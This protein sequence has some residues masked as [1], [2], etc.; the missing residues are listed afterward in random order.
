[1]IRSAIF[2]LLLTISC[3]IHAELCK[4]IDSGGS[5]HYTS[6]PPDSSWRLVECYG[7]DDKAA[8]QP[9][10]RPPVLGVG[11]PSILPQCLEGPATLGV[12]PSARARECTRQY[13][14]RPEYREKVNTYAM[15]QRQSESDQNIALTCI[16]RSEQDLVKK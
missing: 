1:M 16:T 6:T 2:T 10:S 12:G 11:P 13:C 15:N 4:Y 9:Q 14:A 7:G 8:L 3:G 5:N